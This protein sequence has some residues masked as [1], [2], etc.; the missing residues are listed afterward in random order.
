MWYS[1]M[2]IRDP[3]IV[4]HDTDCVPLGQSQ[5][6]NL[7]HQAFVEAN[8]IISLKERLDKLY[9]IC[10]VVKKIYDR[11]QEMPQVWK[12][13][14]KSNVKKQPEQNTVYFQY[15]LTLDPNSILVF[16]TVHSETC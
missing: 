2:H 5:S 10:L 8:L 6:P 15:P 1:G 3:G 14:H 13:K 16:S 7:S 12:R 4:S 9:N 11:N